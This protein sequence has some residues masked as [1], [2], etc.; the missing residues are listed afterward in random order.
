MAES[1]AQTP[2]QDEKAAPAQATDAAAE[3]TEK[4]GTVTNL[5]AS[6]KLSLSKTDELLARL[7]RSAG[8][9][10][11]ALGYVNYGIFLLAYL[12]SVSAPSRAKLIAGLQK[13]IGGEPKAAASLQPS[14]T[15][16]NPLGALL[17]DTRTTLRLTGLLPLSVLL[18]SLLDKNSPRRA[19]PVAYKI[20][21]VQCLSFIGFQLLENVGH[22]TRKG[23]IPASFIAN[24]GGEGAWAQWSCRSWL[25]G[26][27]T[28]FLRLAREAQVNQQKKEKGQ[29]T[30]QEQKAFEATWWAGLRTS[31]AWLP[32]AL[33]Y[34]LDGGL[35]FMNPGLIALSGFLAY[36]GNFNNAWAATKL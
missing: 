7:V 8:D 6:G 3:K 4:A 36:R 28:D 23:V 29:I 2:P 33:H 27:L 22:L 11:A 21:L 10:N 32:M 19:D 1:E 35:P 9:F 34:S 13:A 16:L 30:A 20:A 5:P 25:L 15:F 18:R 31:L 17:S 14:S 24:R 26:I 12:H